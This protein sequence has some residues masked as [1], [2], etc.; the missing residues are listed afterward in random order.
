[1]D[2]TGPLNN[3]K[4]ESIEVMWGTRDQEAVTAP[5]LRGQRREWYYWWAESPG[6]VE[7]VE[8]GGK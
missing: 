1:M 6:A 4:N 2:M 7:G 5:T 8:F 3:N